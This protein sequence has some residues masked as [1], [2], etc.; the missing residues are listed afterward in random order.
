MKKEVLKEGCEV[1]YIVE[2]NV[3][4]GNVFNIEY[5]KDGYT[6]SIDSYGACEGSYK[7]D[8]SVIGISVFLNKEDAIRLANDPAYIGGFHAYC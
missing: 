4:S 3:L 8:A 5:N 2:H 1:F 6:F 7:I